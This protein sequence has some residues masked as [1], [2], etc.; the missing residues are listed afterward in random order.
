MSSV[1]LISCVVLNKEAKFLDDFKFE[2][3]FNCVEALPDDLEWKLTYVGCPT[4]S[5]YDQVLDS[6]LLGPVMLGIN[7]FVFEVRTTTSH[8]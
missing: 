1:S 4:D 2:I 3:S 5:K 6:I 7:K 8:L